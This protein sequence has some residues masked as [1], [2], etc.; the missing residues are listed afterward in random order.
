M[1][2]KKKYLYLSKNFKN[3]IEYI[4]LFILLSYSDT[5]VRFFKILTFSNNKRKRVS[6][7]FILLF[8]SQTDILRCNIFFMQKNNNTSIG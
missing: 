8:I 3:F 2:L 7:Y 1:F 6:C 4:V 5:P